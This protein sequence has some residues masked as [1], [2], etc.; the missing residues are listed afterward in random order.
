MYPATVLV[1]PVVVEYTRPTAM[2]GAAARVTERLAASGETTR[3]ELAQ[4]LTSLLSVSSCS[5]ERHVL[6]R[7]KE[8]HEC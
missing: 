5:L 7:G 1:L 8:S 2:F 3:P 6:V 4:K